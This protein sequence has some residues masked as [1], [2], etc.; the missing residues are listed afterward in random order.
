MEWT[1]FYGVQRILSI[2]SECTPVVHVFHDAQL[3]VIPHS[4]PERMTI[5]IEL[6]DMHD[7]ARRKSLL[8]TASSRPFPSHHAPISTQRYLVSLVVL[9]TFSE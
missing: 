3:I 7:C 5:L 2:G 4:I 1:A 9:T 8:I 6:L